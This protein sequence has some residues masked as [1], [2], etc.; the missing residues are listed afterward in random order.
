MGLKKL[1]QLLWVDNSE[2]ALPAV[3]RGQS[4][5]HDV[6]M[7][8]YAGSHRVDNA[9]WRRVLHFKGAQPSFAGNYTCIASY[10]GYIYSY[11]TVDIQVSGE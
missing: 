4:S 2:V 8:R 9:T 1:R 5:D 3:D 6:Y 10:N 11:Q 7:E